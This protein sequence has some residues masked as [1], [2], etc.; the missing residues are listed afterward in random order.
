MKKDTRIFKGISEGFEL[1]GSVPQYP[2]SRSFKIDYMTLSIKP[3]LADDKNNLE[4]CQEKLDIVTLTDLNEII[5]D[6]AEIKV[7]SVDL[8]E[9]MSD[10]N[11]S[12]KINNNIKRLIESGNTSDFYNTENTEW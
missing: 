12:N 6:I 10:K 9:N 11:S 5:L 8:S 3:N 2:P 4:N 1:P 7:N